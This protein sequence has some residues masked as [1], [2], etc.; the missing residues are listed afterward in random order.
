MRV[1]F[2]ITVGQRTGP[3]YNV[4]EVADL[5][6]IQAADFLARGLVERVDD[7]PAPRSLDTPP[8]D[9]AMRR[10]GVTRR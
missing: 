8:Q 9:R 1:R 4:G 3:Q 2:K 7:A 6:D 10:G 5:D